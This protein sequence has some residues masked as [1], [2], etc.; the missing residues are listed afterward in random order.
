MKIRMILLLATT[1]LLAACAVGPD[2][3]APKTAPVAAAPFTGAA[4]PAFT[5]EAAV[6][7]WWTLYSDPLL[8][9]MVDDALK[10][11]TDIR[12]AAAR[13]ERARALL[14]NAKSARLPNTTLDAS[15]TRERFSAAQL[16]SANSNAKP[17]TMMA[18]SRSPMRSICSAA[19][20]AVS[21]RPM[22]TGRPSKP[23]PMRCGWR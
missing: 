23:M 17:G 1:S 18:G 13:V 15:A 7:H 19:C 11:N 10:A 12:V 4:S 9:R 16:N 2:Y 20:G 3:K 8:D 22:A 5:Q 6:D 14:R 21:R